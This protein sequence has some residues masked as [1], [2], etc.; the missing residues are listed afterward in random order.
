MT[1]FPLNKYLVGTSSMMSEL[2]LLLKIA[3]HGFAICTYSDQKVFNFQTSKLKEYGLENKVL[4]KEKKY[5]GKEEDLI[6]YLEAEKNN[7]SEK[8]KEKFQKW[9]TNYERLAFSISGLEEKLESNDVGRLNVLRDYFLSFEYFVIIWIPDTYLKDIPA[10]APDFWRI[11]SK[12]FQFDRS[13]RHNEL[14]LGLLA[15]SPHDAQQ[16]FER[17]IYRNKENPILCNNKGLSLLKQEKYDE[18]LDSFE[19]AVKLNP[20]SVRFL[21]NY[22]V[23]RCLLKQHNK[24]IPLFRSGVKIDSNDPALLLNYGLALMKLGRFRTAISNFNKVLSIE[25]KNRFAMLNLSKAYFQTGKFHR[26]MDVLEKLLGENPDYADAMTLSG[27]THTKLGNFSHAETLLNRAVA[28]APSDIEAIYNKA[29]LHHKMKKP[30]LALNEFDKVLSQD[31]T[32]ADALREK[33]KITRK[34]KK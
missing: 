28:L 32:H 1:T 31:P 3:K 24:S 10:K 33:K 29:I 20:K 15:D 4:V 2:I 21:N 17:A 14:G 34:I 27:A 16:C 9:A 30:D 19:R 13:E 18:A 12:V 26:A 11:R 6:E 22:A 25:P 5:E 23:N 7:F 8:I